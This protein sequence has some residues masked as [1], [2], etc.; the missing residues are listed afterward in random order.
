VRLG[1]TY[2]HVSTDLLHRIWQALTDDTHNP[3]D[4]PLSLAPGHHVGERALDAWVRMQDTH[5]G[6][7]TASNNTFVMSITFQPAPGIGPRT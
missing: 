3:A 2:H 5:G 7:H 6:L 1:A 4:I